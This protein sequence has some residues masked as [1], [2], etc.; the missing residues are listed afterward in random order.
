GQAEVRPGSR[1]RGGPRKESKE[2]QGGRSQAEEAPKEEGAAAHLRPLG[3]LRR[4]DETGRHLRLQS[5]AA[6]RAEDRRHRGQEAERCIFSADRQG[7]DARTGARG[8]AGKVNHECLYPGYLP[9][10]ETS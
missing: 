3:R 4:G 2:A 1:R 5:E 6:R 8:G 9:K 10:R 7:T